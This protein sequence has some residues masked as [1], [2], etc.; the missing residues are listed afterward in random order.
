MLNLVATLQ[1]NLSDPQRMKLYRGFLDLT[2]AQLAEEMGT[3]Q[4]SVGRWESGISPISLMTMNHVRKLVEV[5]I[6]NAA[7][8]F[9]GK[10]G[11]DLVTPDFGI[12]GTPC[13]EPEKDNQGNLYFGAF[14]IDGYRE[15]SLYIRVDNRL[16]YGLDRD[17]R[18]V[19]VDEDFVKSVILARKSF[20]DIAE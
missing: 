10:F 20:A 5:R 3:T 8:L 17:K 2:Q 6:M 4:T 15:H 16:W 14:I 11:R 1:E 9:I 18:A 12:S 19:A 13:T 7:Q